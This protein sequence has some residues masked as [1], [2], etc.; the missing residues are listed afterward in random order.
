MLKLKPFFKVFNLYNTVPVLM[1]TFHIQCFK[2]GDVG[3]K[4]TFHSLKNYSSAYFFNSI[5]YLKNKGEIT[6]YNIVAYRSVA[7]QW[8]CKQHSFLGNSR[9]ADNGTTSVAM[10]QILNK[11]EYMAA[12]GKRLGK[13]VPVATDMNTMIEERCFLC[14]P[15]WDVISRRV[16][17]E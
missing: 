15:C 17:E 12:A 9:E 13:H 8:L 10:Q 5:S 6:L 7:K 4:E 14:G 2:R 1:A 3:K 16:S 11:Q